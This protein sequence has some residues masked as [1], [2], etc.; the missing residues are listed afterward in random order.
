MPRQLLFFFF[1]CSSLLRLVGSTVYKSGVQHDVLISSLGAVGCVPCHES[2]YG[3]NLKSQDMMSC[4]GPYLFVG[5]QKVNKKVLE[6]GALAS[7]EVLRTDASRSAPYLSNGVYWYFTKGCSFGFTAVDS[8]VDSIKE[9]SGRSLSH[10]NHGISWIMDHSVGCTS[11]DDL[12]TN[13]LVDTSKWRK[14]IY[15]CPGACLRHATILLGRIISYRAHRK[16]FTS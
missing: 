7:V 2:T 4:T 16:Q 1:S 12:K 3:S 9:S 13:E 8:N 14:H 11:L 10:T 5:N 15:N 6:I